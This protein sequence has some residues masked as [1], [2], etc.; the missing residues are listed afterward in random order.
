VLVETAGH[1]HTETVSP[2]ARTLPG[3]VVYRFAGS[4]YYANANHFLED[5]T[6]FAKGSG[7]CDLV[8]FCVDGAAT[9]DIDY[10]G[11]ETLRQAHS[12]LI[13]VGAELVMCDLLPEAR[14]SLEQYGF[15]EL[16]GNDAVFDTMADVIQ[17]YEQLQP[18]A[19]S[20]QAE[21]NQ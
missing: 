13:A 20:D 1:V 9:P 8:W 15:I 10:T 18:A 21:P 7:D 6:M 5:V 12:Q 16:I 14:A 11:G 17:A 4:L 3:L 19:S 2:A